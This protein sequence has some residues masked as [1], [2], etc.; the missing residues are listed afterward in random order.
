M[1]WDQ[2]IEKASDEMTDLEPWVYGR[3]GQPSLFA[4]VLLK[5]IHLRPQE[6]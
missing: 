3:D 1:D 5:M 4:A 2:L 6:C